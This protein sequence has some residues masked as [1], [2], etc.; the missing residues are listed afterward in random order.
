[1][2][3]QH[4]FLYTV[5]IFLAELVD[6]LL[7]WNMANILFWLEGCTEERVQCMYNVMQSN[8]TNVVRYRSEALHND[9]GLRPVYH[10]SLKK[11]KK[12]AL[13]TFIN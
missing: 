3:L 5:D 13:L 6:F 9:V 2:H 4:G 11:K 1:M 8:N 7:R 10:S 12:D